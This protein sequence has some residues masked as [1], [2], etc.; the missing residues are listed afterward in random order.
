LCQG[1]HAFDGE[2]L[3]VIAEVFRR[4][5]AGG[6]LIIS[7][8]QPA[9]DERAIEHLLQIVD[10]TEGALVLTPAGVVLPEVAG[11][12]EDL[13][14][15]L[16]LDCQIE[17]PE[18]LTIDELIAYCRGVGLVMLGGNLSTG[19]KE[20]L[21]SSLFPID[22]V[23]VLIGSAASLVGEWTYDPQ[24]QRIEEGLHW[25]PGGLILT[26]SGPVE[27]AQDVLRHKHKS[28]V[29]NLG[30]SAALALGPA[31]EIELWG[32]PAPSIVLGR[33]WGES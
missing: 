20:L 8:P 21:C 19:W 32:S 16:E 15:L 13:E 12:L 25:L 5:I 7:G 22:G 1:C 28:Y 27:A 2:D 4:S 3:K 6:W 29:L 31:G 14:N 18:S 10:P 26:D 9:L 23:L 33:G 24:T 30:E 11:W 17:D